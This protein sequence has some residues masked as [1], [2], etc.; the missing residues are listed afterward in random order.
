[1]LSNQCERFDDGGDLCAERHSKHEI[2]VLARHERFVEFADIMKECSSCHDGL[3]R[4]NRVAVDHS[5]KD[6]TGVRLVRF[7]AALMRRCSIVVNESESGCAP[8]CFR[9]RAQLRQL[10]LELE[11]EPQVIRVEK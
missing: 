4:N 5:V 8:L 11:R 1:M 6:P 9:S 10:A 2:E 7:A 3:N